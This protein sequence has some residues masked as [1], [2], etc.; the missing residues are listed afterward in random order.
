MQRK[1]EWLPTG[2]L[3]KRLEPKVAVELIK[4]AR[5]T[6]PNETN[7]LIEIAMTQGKENIRIAL[8]AVALER[9]LN[10][11]EEF[12]RLKWLLALIAFLTFLAAAIQAAAAVGVLT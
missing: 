9:E 10:R 2:E 5:S 11:A 3:E 1:Y 6:D 7:D 8:E 4:L 12:K